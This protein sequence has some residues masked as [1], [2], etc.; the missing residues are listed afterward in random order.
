MQNFNCMRF[1]RAVSG[2]LLVFLVLAFSTFLNLQAA[3]SWSHSDGVTGGSVN[4]IAVNPQDPSTL[5]VAAGTGGIFKSINGGATWTAINNGIIPITDLRSLAI[6]PQDPSTVYAG[7]IYNGVFKST[8]GGANWTQS[9]VGLFAP[10]YAIAIDPLNSN[11]IYAG[12]G[13]NNPFSYSTNGG[14]S[15]HQNNYDVWGSHLSGFR[16]YSLAFAGT[17]QPRLYAVGDMGLSFKNNSGW[18]NCSSYFG[19]PYSIQA[20]AIDPKNPTTIYVGSNP[21]GVFKTGDGGVTWTSMN[22]GLADTN[23]TALVIDPQDSA[24]IYAGTATGGVF[25]SY[26]GG[27]SWNGINEGLADQSIRTLAFAPTTPPR[28]FAGTAS[29]VWIYDILDIP[30]ANIV[31]TTNPPGRTYTVDGVPYSK[32]QRFSWTPGSNHVVSVEELQE[33]GGTRYALT[34]WSDGGEGSH[35]ITAPSSFAIYTANFSTQY[36]LSTS[37]SPQDGGSIE[38]SPASPDGYYAAGTTVEIR[39][40]ANSGYRF[41]GWSGDFTNQHEREILRMNAPH[42]FSAS[43]GTSMVQVSI[44]TN[45]EGLEFTVDGVTYSSSKY[46]AWSSASSHTVS[47]RTPQGSGGQRYVFGNWSDGGSI[48]HT[49]VVPYSDR[50]YVASFIVQYRLTTSVVPTNGGTLSVDPASTDGYYNSGSSVLLSYTANTNYTFSS[51][52]GDLTGSTNYQILVMNAPRNVTANYAAITPGILITTNPAGRAITVDGISYTSE[53]VFPWVPGTIH[54]ISVATPQDA[55]GT[56]YVFTNWSDEGSVSHTIITPSNAA[57]YVANFAS[58]YRLTTTVSPPYGGAL[59]ITPASPDGY[60]AIDTNVQLT[61]TASFGYVFAGWSGDLS[62]NANPQSLAIS[63]HRNVTAMF[64]PNGSAINLALNS[65]G[66]ATANTMGFG[67][68]RTGYADVSINTGSTPYGTAVF[69]LTQNGVVVSEAGVPASPPTTSAR[70][71]IDYRTG[72]YAI[73]ARNNAGTININTG[74]ALV[75][76]GS[77]TAYVTYILRDAN[78]SIVAGGHGTIAAKSHITGFIDQ[79]KSAAAPDFNFPSDFQTG[80]LEIISDQ[81]LSVLALRGTMNQRNEF[82]MTTTPIA[83]LKQPLESSSI[84][85]PQF[86]DGDGSTTS[87]ILLNTSSQTETGVLE[88]RD[89][90]G[91]P[92]AMKQVGGTLDSTFN[93]S[94]PPGGVFQFQS[95]GSSEE[96]KKGWVVLTPTNG[97]MTPVSSGVFGYNPEDVLV[98]ESGIPSVVAT[99]HARIYVDLSKKHNT[100]LAVANISNSNTSIVIKA[101]LKDGITPAGSSEGPLMLPAKGHTAAFADQFISGLPQGFTGVL[102]ISSLIPFAALTIRSLDNERGEFLMTTFPVAD[103]NQTAPSPIIFPQIADGGGSKTEFILISPGGQANTSLN[104]YDNAGAAWDFVK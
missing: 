73:P 100:G 42:S 53:Q 18:F 85:F 35:A 39:A 28:L 41:T 45:P 56:R 95:D 22:T 34:S 101:Y 8:N 63:A 88:I 31:I 23:I 81:A 80:S 102:D 83:D 21:D 55:G 74:I 51:W 15:W 19:G 12:G 17:A 54:T 86:A 84:Y 48:S 46:F 72:V 1:S 27:D 68:L 30:T 91:N 33:S 94:I 49:I 50:S 87:L 57:T 76:C 92:L 97:T 89:N 62:G 71:F 99:T 7:A 13:S 90:D 25:V 4:A 61:A 11:N 79:L 104:L 103:A 65:G 32:T 3:D 60:Y 16:V 6:D 47:V 98:S 75:N 52:S 82:L 10:V 20:L 59:N 14:T 2:L 93:Y 38:L 9:S 58:Q 43:F 44:T 36:H 37:V 5:Y 70:I 78:A 96:L 40:V 77:A 64:M 24:T 26:D 67:S 66:A 29:G 69:S